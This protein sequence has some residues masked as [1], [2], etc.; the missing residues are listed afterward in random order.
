MKMCATFFRELEYLSISPEKGI[1]LLAACLIFSLTVFMVSLFTEVKIPVYFIPGRG[2]KYCD[3]CVCVSLLLYLTVLPVSL[4][5][6][7]CFD[8]VGWAAGRASGL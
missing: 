2:A 6:L 5:C 1:L 8:A 3:H 4:Y 7:Q